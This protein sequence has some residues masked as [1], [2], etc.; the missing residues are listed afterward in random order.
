ML[1]SVDGWGNLVP[2]DPVPMIYRRYSKT[3]VNLI[4]ISFEP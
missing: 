4:G 3:P 2:R 1:I